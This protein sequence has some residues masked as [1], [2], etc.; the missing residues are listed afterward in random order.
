VMKPGNVENGIVY[1]GDSTTYTFSVK[2]ADKRSIP[3]CL[4]R[5]LEEKVIPVTHGSYHLGIYRDFIKY[6]AKHSQP[7]AIIIPINMRSFSAEWDTRPEYQFKKESLLLNLGLMWSPLYKPLSIYTDFFNDK[8]DK[9]GW[10]DSEVLDNGKVAGK[11]RDFE[12]I[13]TKNP[14]ASDMRKRII[15]QYRYELAS[16]HRKLLALH[17]ICEVAKK[18]RIN[19]L[20]YITPVDLDYID[21]VYSGTSALVGKNVGTVKDVISSCGFSVVDLSHSIPSNYFDWKVNGFPNEH[22]NEK[23]RLFV[24]ARLQSELRKMKLSRLSL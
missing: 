20:F 2:D 6:L 3:A 11:I 8:L 10:L 21:G 17:D 4:Q 9:S 16:D 5:G 24:A 23:G 13:G 14:S 18:Q 7:K 15:F 1:F 12:D 19:I 22:M